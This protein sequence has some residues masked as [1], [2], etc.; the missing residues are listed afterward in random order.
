MMK[1]Q[2]DIEN[3]YEEMVHMRRHMH[4]H[5]ELSF[6]EA[7]TKQ[8]IYEQISDLGLDIRQNVGGNGIVARLDID[9]DFKTI[10][11]RADFD[12]LPIE[13]EKDVPY[14]STVPGIMH[15]CGHDAHTA[16]LITTARIL[17]ARKEELKV[18][19]VFLFQ[20]AEEML[21]GGAQAM[22]EDGA[23]DGVDYIFGT[24][25]SSLYP[26]GTLSYT[27]DFAYAAADAFTITVEGRG[28]HGAEPHE[29]VDPVVAGASL[30]QQLQSIVSRTVDPL[31]S[32]VVTTSMFNGGSSFN[33]I[34]NSVELRGTIRTFE[35]SV[36]D[37][38]LRR[39]DGIIKG[40]ESSFEVTCKLDYQHGYPALL[41]NNSQLDHVLHSL[42]DAT[43]VK[44]A[45]ENP[46]SMGGEDFA[47]YLEKVPGCYFY[48]GVRNP[49]KGID[50]PHHHPLFD[51]DEDGLKAGVESLCSIVLNFNE[52]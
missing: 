10:A 6:K 11:L 50:H 7:E 28:G 1:I 32:A 17:A 21:P 18:N 4:M 34:P 47:Y 38:V 22:I 44:I 3:L 19:V 15:A 14:R 30:I 41:N 16:M 49:E 9:D 48:T 52:Y 36:K 27:K 5:P 31:K 25:V 8:Y 26:T 29:A 43:Y 42:E 51:I 20:H 13:D 35:Q 39:M 23:L 40:I 12:A 46:P 33:V 45:E 2:Q 37:D 24:H